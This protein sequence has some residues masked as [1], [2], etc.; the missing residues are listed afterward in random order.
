MCNLLSGTSPRILFL[1]YKCLQEYLIYFLKSL[2]AASSFK[3]GSINWFF[4]PLYISL[5]TEKPFT[6]ENSTALHRATTECVPTF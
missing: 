6:E 5:R 1:I 3:F 4:N 2:S